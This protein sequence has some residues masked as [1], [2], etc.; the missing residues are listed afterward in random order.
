[1]GGLD[2]NGRLKWAW[3]FENVIVPMAGLLGVTYA[4]L[5]GP[6]PPGLYPVLAGMIGYPGVRAI[7]K[8]RRGDSP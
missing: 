5:G 6:V 7:D 3:V 2:G 1:V 8:A 4:S